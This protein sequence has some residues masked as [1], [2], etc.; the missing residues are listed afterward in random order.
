MI[1]STEIMYSYSLCIFP[2]KGF[3]HLPQVNIQEYLTTS[4]PTDTM[5]VTT[6]RR[7]LPLFNTHSSLI[8]GWKCWEEFCS[9]SAPSSLWETGARVKKPP[10]RLRSRRQSFMNS[11]EIM[12]FKCWNCQVCTVQSLQVCNLNVSFICL[13]NGASEGRS[14]NKAR[15]CP[16]LVRC[17]QGHLSP[18]RKD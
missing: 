9:W 15:Q 12:I 16:C 2:E 3:L 5:S 4:W 17:S 18:E 14:W 1:F 13:L 7:H 8:L 6:P 11:N 10:R